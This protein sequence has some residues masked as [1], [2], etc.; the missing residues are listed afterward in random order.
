M[1]FIYNGMTGSQVM[2]SFAQINASECFI[3][4]FF[5]QKHK[6][7]RAIFRWETLIKYSKKAGKQAGIVLLFFSP[8][9]M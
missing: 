9:K 6:G 5:K 1:Y 8:I 2:T 4:S 3:V 7:E